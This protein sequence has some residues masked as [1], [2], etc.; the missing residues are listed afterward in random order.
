[1]VNLK[2]FILKPI[3]YGFLIVSLI[4]LISYILITY[5]S[6]IIMIYIHRIF[7]ALIFIWIIGC[8]FLLIKNDR[9][10]RQEFEKFL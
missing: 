4:I 10:F 7:C 2:I 5:T 3:F 9:K 1:M 6:D 8:V